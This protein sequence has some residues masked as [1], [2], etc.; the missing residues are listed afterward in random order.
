MYRAK[1]LPHLKFNTIL[2]PNAPTM[3]KLLLMFLLYLTVAPVYA[4][5]EKRAVAIMP[6]A[7]TAREYKG[8]AALIQEM[9]VKIIA[10]R[11]NIKLIDRSNDSLIFKELDN[12]LNETSADATVFAEQGKL[13]GAREMIVGTLT[14]LFVSEAITNSINDPYSKNEIKYSARVGF[15]LQLIDVATGIVKETELIE[16]STKKSEITEH[17]AKSMLEILGK[18][19]GKDQNKNLDKVES[20]GDL[21]IYKTPSEAVKKAIEVCEKK[22]LKWA[23]KIFQ[24]EIRLIAV[25]DRKDDVPETILV[26]GLDETFKKKSKIIVSEVTFL[27]A[28]GEKIKRVIKLAELRMLDRQGEVIKCK[29]TEG[30]KVI[31]EKM[32]NGSILE[33]LIKQ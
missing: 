22:I 1:F 33:Y 19:F 27:E 14:K 29:I 24:A 18:K 21:L 23:N 15:S 20:L 32:K 3:K 2:N 30:N 25:E 7:Y 28:G 5:D 6:F 13:I 26:S 11:S 10:N 17:I 9:V 31:E 12:Q 8:T 4:Q 16:G